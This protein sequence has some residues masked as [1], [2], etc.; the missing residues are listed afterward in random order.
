MGQPGLS[1][2]EQSV[3][4]T[5]SS[6]MGGAGSKILPYLATADFLLNPPR[7]PEDVMVVGS[8]TQGG[9]PIVTQTQPWGPSALSGGFRGAMA[10]APFGPIGIGVGAAIGFLGGKR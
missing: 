10:G 8:P 4:Q 1:P 9:Q 3:S 5:L 7:G 2:F 6:G